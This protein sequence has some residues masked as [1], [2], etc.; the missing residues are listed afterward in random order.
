MV[1]PWCLLAGFPLAKDTEA[2]PEAHLP[3][4][5]AGCHTS[6]HLSTHPNMAINSLGTTM[7]SKTTS[8]TRVVSTITVI[9]QVMASRII[10][11]AE[12][13]TV[14]AA[15]VVGRTETTTPTTK[16]EEGII[17]TKK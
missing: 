16:A 5:V 15:A 12:E 10:A 14:E 3:L 17:G 2:T 7:V 8:T 1:P 11:E 4:H 13:V 9:N 6:T